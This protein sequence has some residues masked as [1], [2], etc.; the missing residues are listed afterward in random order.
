M[1]EFL[2][3]VAHLEACNFI[4]NGLQHKCFTVNFAKL[5]KALCRTSPVRG[6]NINSIF[7]ALRPRKTYIYIFPALLFLDISKQLHVPYRS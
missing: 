4:K 6:S 7:L 2:E 3:K 1:P 5:L